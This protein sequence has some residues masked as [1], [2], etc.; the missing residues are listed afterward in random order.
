MIGDISGRLGGRLKRH[1]SHQGGR[2]VDFGFYYLSGK[3][4]WFAPGTKA[5]LDLGRNWAL[6]RALVT[7]TDVDVVLLD[8]RIQRL[9]YQHALSIG[10][11]KEW[12]ERVVGSLGKDKGPAVRSQPKEWPSWY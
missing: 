9:L 5:N 12:R 8:T 2:D 6:V 7:R 10:E 1:E 11:D 3:G 4:T